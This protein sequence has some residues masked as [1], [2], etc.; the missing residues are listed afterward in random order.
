MTNYDKL[1]DRTG[2]G[3]HR[4]A[5]GGPRS[6]AD[7]LVRQFLALRQPSASSPPARIG[8]STNV[9]QLAPNML[10]MPIEE[11][12]LPDAGVQLP[13]AQQH[14]QGRTAAPAFDDDLC[15]CANFRQKVAR[16]E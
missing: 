16:R 3:R 10:D 15:G 2:D 12:D 1:T 8:V 13:E 11:L 14:R 5:R 4:L 9:Q 6:G 7:I